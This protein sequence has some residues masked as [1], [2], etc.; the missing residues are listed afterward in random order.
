MVF[1]LLCAAVPYEYGLFSSSDYLLPS[2]SI[3][4]IL[5][6]DCGPLLTLIVVRWLGH[7]GAHVQ[8]CLAGMKTSCRNDPLMD[9]V[10]DH[11]GC[12]YP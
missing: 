11:A 3:E 12:R 9:R 6:S 2:C 1:L 7:A 10:V 4:L 8:T 5:L